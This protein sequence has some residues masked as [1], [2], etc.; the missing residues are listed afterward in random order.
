MQRARDL[1][2]SS[3]QLFMFSRAGGVENTKDID[4]LEIISDHLGRVG[5]ASKL[6]F[7]Q[8]GLLKNHFK[9][10]RTYERTP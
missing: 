4:S 5:E 1:A 10:S 7:K 3:F 8:V 2:Q 9:P 6:V